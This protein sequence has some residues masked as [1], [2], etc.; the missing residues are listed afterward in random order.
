RAKAAA[1]DSSLRP[2]AGKARSRRP[3]APPRIAYPLPVGGRYPNPTCPSQGMNEAWR[4]IIFGRTH[5]GGP[6]QRKR[7]DLCFTK[8]THF[9]VTCALTDESIRKD[10]SYDPARP[11]HQGPLIRDELRRAG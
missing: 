1:P 8:R 11:G 6:T 7:N 5:F 3:F 2:Q 9:D 4:A 10:S